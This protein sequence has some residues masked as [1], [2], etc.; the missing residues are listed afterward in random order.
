[1]IPVLIVA[2]I[3][4]AIS[5]LL[6]LLANFKVRKK[7]CYTFQTHKIEIFT[8]NYVVKLL[9]DGE[10][11]DKMSF[12]SFKWFNATLTAKVDDNNFIVK[13][14]RKNLISSPKIVITLN[15]EE[16]DLNNL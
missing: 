5:I 8:G 6:T 2:G 15:N 7:L 11:K 13:I 16:I 3:I 10:E 9:I 12:G 14:T 1:M 4:F